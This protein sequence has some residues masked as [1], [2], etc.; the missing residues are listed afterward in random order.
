MP[1]IHQII[2]SVAFYMTSLPTSSSNNVLSRSI[3]FRHGARGPGESELSAWEKDHPVVA[4]WKA[5]E[6]ENLSSIGE[7][8]MKSLGRWFCGKCDDLGQK[9]ND[10]KFSTSKSSRA[11]ESGQYFVDAYSNT[12]LI[13]GITTNIVPS[14]Y[15]TDADYYFRPWKVYTEV[16]KGSKAN[17]ANSPVWQN[18][19]KANNELLM[20]V[21]RDLGMKAALQATPE[22]ILWSLTYVVNELVCEEFWPKSESPVDQRKNLHH[23]MSQLTEV[24]QRILSLACW[25]WDIR[26]VSSGFQVDLGGWLLLDMIQ[27]LFGYKDGQSVQLFAGHDYTIISVLAAAGLLTSL[28]EPVEWGAYIIMELCDTAPR[29]A[30]SSSSITTNNSDSPLTQSQIPSQNLELR[31]Y[32]NR[33]PFGVA[34]EQ[35]IDSGN[36][37]GTAATAVEDDNVTVHP[38]REILLAVLSMPQLKALIECVCGV[39]NEH[40]RGLPPGFLVPEL[41]SQTL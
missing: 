28:T 29:T 31:I 39:L 23:L 38:E 34:I 32:H 27:K 19:V 2:F 36:T 13:S 41:I 21:W 30:S 8:Q 1:S 33:Q 7:I 9:A 3:L 40:N 35:N 16:E 14:T 10:V 5:E 6:I 25:V 24:K 4:Q 37:L 15:T 26:F 22:R 20:A 18:Q 17:M 12:K 11:A